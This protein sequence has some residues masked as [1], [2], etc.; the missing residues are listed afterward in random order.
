M[1]DFPGATWLPNN[2]FFSGRNGNKPSFIIIHGTAGG[3]SAQG[4][5]SGF[6]SSE[7]GG[8]PVSSH[9]IIGTDGTVV[10]TVLESNS[11][12][13]N[14]V[15]S[16]T[17]TPNLPFRTVGDG[18]HRDDWWNTSINPNYQTISIEHCKPDTENVAALTP[19]QQASS[20][21]LIKDICQRNNIPMR[22]ADANGGITGH[23]SVDVA[24][25]SFCPNTYPWD[26][27]W[28][29]LNNG[30]N[31]MDSVLN[32]G[33]TDD[34]TNKVL[35]GPNGVPVVLGCRDH[36]L[37][38]KNNWDPNN[39]PLSAEHAANPVEQ[40]NPSLGPGTIQNFRWKRLEYTAKSGVIEAWLGQELEW[41]EKQYASQQAQIVSLKSQP[42]VANLLA[43][44]TLASQIVQK[45]QV[46]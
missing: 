12:W 4:I 16:G 45:S 7:S 43:I 44:N 6:V 19:V 23:F 40:S 42:N 39:W 18:I 36:V 27:L 29:Y 10:Q 9:Y 20:F 31:T 1:S 37:D 34:S 21:A 17:P 13:G 25:R 46:Q 11:A 14:G 15:I 2:N 8:N 32:H 30:G 35:K 41:H 26:A 3:I 24:E 28:Q 22:F 5:A 38:P 33:W